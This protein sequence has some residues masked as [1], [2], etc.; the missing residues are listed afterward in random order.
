MCE[1]MHE[2]LSQHSK[3]VIIIQ[4][5]DGIGRALFACSCLLF[6][7]YPTANLQDVVTFTRN[8][9]IK[10]A[11]PKQD[12]FGFTQSVPSQKR[13]YQYFATLMAHCYAIS[14]GEHIEQVCVFSFI[15]F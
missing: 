1:E 15:M 8:E 6:Y 7:Y 5:P 11:D 13:Y 14:L 3:N 12:Q 9:R 2:Y 4:S 10:E